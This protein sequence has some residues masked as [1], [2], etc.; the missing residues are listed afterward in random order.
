[1]AQQQFVHCSHGP[2]A[3]S[4][5]F[6]WP[7]SSISKEHTTITSQRAGLESE[8]ESSIFDEDSVC[9]KPSLNEFCEID[10]EAIDCDSVDLKAKV[11]ELSDRLA[12]ITISTCKH[13]RR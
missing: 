4:S 6:P 7:N 10:A 2:T 5:L 13:Q 12:E 3:V 1:M 8:S 9:S 11:A